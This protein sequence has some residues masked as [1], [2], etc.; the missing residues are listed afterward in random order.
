MAACGLIRTQSLL[1]SCHVSY[2]PSAE[3]SFLH[4][5]GRPFILNLSKVRLESAVEVLPYSRCPSLHRVKFQ[6]RASL[7]EDMAGSEPDE[8]RE[9]FGESDDIVS[10]R[11]R[12]EASL[13]PAPRITGRQ[14]RELVL[15][16]YGCSYDVRLCKFNNRV[17]LQIMWKCLEQRSF[18]LTEEMYLE[19]LDAVAEFL[20]I[21][22]VADKVR[23]YVRTT[24]QRPGYTGGGGAKAVSVPLDIGRGERRGQEWMD[25][26]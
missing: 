19:Q 15:A 17:Y 25:H 23:N 6:S 24:K 11:V 8:V 22:G 14:I 9:S 10:A 20:N 3:C 26:F 5:S 7:R 2:L 16:K 12:L 1:Q 4:L 21:W 13:Q 18:H